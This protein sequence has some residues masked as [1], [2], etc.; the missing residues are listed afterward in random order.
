MDNHRNK[1]KT[2]KYTLEQIIHP[3]DYRNRKTA[4]VCTIGPGCNNVDTLGQMLE[5]G[6]TVARLNFSHGDHEYHG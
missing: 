1:V 3:I 2:V 6:M 5:R 4:I